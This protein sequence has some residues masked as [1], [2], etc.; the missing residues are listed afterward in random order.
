MNVFTCQKHGKFMCKSKRWIQCVLYWLKYVFVSFF[1]WCRYEIGEALYIGWAS[2]VLAICGGVC[3]MFSCKLGT[4]KKTWVVVFFITVCHTP[5]FLFFTVLSH[6]THYCYLLKL[7]LWEHIF[8]ILH[9]S[10]AVLTPTIPPVKQFTQR[11]H[12]GEK[13]R[14]LMEK[15]LT[16][17]SSNS[18]QFHFKS[19]VGCWYSI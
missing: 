3:L 2:A 7:C 11:P 18:G 8:H 5:L 4:E 1:L 6:F 10:L 16:C 9:H 12:P 19:N 13:P 14:A 17:K 15:M